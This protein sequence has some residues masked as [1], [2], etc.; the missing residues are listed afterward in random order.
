MRFSPEH[1]IIIGIRFSIQKRDPDRDQNPF[2]K[3]P[4]SIFIPESITGFQIKIDLRLKT[5]LS[6]DNTDGVE[7]GD[8]IFM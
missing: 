8:P 4:V 6:S 1:E 7:D 5:G 3:N 2:R